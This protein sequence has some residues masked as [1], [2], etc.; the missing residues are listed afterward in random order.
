MP[1]RDPHTI[2][3]NISM[4]IET[5]ETA[6]AAK[7]LFDRLLESV[8]KQAIGEQIGAL[9]QNPVDQLKIAVSAA[10]FDVVRTIRGQL[11]LMSSRGIEASSALYS[12]EEE[13]VN[14]EED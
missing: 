4:A 11:D 13:E 7:G 5:G 10:K 9:H 3:D 1:S 8:E 2:A 6:S 12:V 14:G